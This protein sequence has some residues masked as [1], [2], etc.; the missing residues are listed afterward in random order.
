MEIRYREPS[1]NNEEI[2]C[3]ELISFLFIVS[4]MDKWDGNFYSTSEIIFRSPDESKDWFLTEVASLQ[5]YGAVVTS[6]YRTDRRFDVSDV[7][8]L[9]KEQGTSVITDK[10]GQLTRNSVSSNINNRPEA[11]LLPRDWQLPTGH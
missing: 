4:W 8:Q 11:W 2:E 7:D 3:K 1:T 9:I 5:A 6:C 10:T